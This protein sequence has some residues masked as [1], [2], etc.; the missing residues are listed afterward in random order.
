VK[1]NGAAL[2]EAAHYAAAIVLP[3]DGAWQVEGLQGWFQPYKVGTL[4]VPGRL[5]LATPPAEMHLDGHADH[6]WGAIHPPNMPAGTHP[7]AVQAGHSHDAVQAQAVS[8]KANPTTTPAG[9]QQ[10][11]I[12][13]GAL[14]LLVAGSLGLL[15]GVG[16]TMVGRRVAARIRSGQPPLP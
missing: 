9:P 3:H 1:F 13:A 7:A 14:G 4:S 8:L 12:V 5:S 10:P 15:A 2:P 11:S 16:L 6:A